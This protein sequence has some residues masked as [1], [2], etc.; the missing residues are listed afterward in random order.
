MRSLQIGLVVAA[1]LGGLMSCKGSGDHQNGNE[2]PS[3]FIE[4]E[5]I[6]TDRRC[7]GG[8]NIQDIGAQ[9]EG[10]MIIDR[11]GT[12]AFADFTTIKCFEGTSPQSTLLVA[13]ENV[14]KV[15][16]LLDPKVSSRLAE[17][18]GIDDVRS[19]ETSPGLRLRGPEEFYHVAFSVK[20]YTSG[21]YDT[22]F[23]SIEIG[24]VEILERL[25]TAAELD[26]IDGA[27]PPEL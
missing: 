19:R 3:G 5:D 20:S 4:V 23:D 12:F 11:R 27:L 24:S 2:A 1:V 10:V 21:A 8:H 15:D 6:K 13:S 9:L 14:A 17:H 26:S 25:G 7:W 22:S 16:T 18:L